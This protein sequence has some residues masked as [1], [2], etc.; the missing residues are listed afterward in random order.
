[1]SRSGPFCLDPA[2]RRGSGQQQFRMYDT[3]TN[4]DPKAA[5]ADAFQRPRP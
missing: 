1:M 4:G 5:A 3:N 2:F